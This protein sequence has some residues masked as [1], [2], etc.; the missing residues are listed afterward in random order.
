MKRRTL[1][2]ALAALL[3]LT[4]GCRKNDE[5]EPAKPRPEGTAPTTSPAA[6]LPEGHPP[7]SFDKSGGTLPASLSKDGPGLVWTPPPSWKSEP[8]SSGMRKAQY[9]VPRTESDSEDAECAVFAGIGGGAK[10]NARRWVDQF[11]PPEGTAAADSSKVEERTSGGR[12]VT[13]VE[14]RG[15]FTAAGMGGGGGPKPGFALL[16]AIVPGPDGLWF[17][18]L[19][20]PQKTIEAQRVPFRQMIDSIQNKP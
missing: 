2:W 18:K 19:V 20:G 16:G 12:E 17:F 4:S 15:T 5:L 1:I 3:P 13:F 9:R 11:S 8:P 10:E 6:G 14:A 7:V